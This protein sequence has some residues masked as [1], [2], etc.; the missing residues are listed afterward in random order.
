[1]NRTP[2]AK[3]ARESQTLAWVPHQAIIRSGRPPRSRPHRRAPI[4]DALG[5]PYGGLGLLAPGAA[6]A[7]MPSARPRPRVPPA[8]R[9]SPGPSVRRRRA[10]KQ[11]PA[12]AAGDWAVAYVGVH[13]AALNDASKRGPWIHRALWSNW[14]SVRVN[15]APMGY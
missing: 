7:M 4:E 8:M 3:A 9:C 11:R 1:M 13:R 6:A 2:R 14:A 10:S 12:V 5:P 15:V